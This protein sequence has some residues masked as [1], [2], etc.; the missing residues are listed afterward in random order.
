MISNDNSE[1]KEISNKVDKKDGPI[2]QE[3]IIKMNATLISG[4][5]EH[6]SS[7]SSTNNNDDKILPLIS[8]GKERS[9]SF[10]DSDEKSPSI[11]T[12]KSFLP[13]TTGGKMCSALKVH[14]KCFL[15]K[16]GNDEEENLEQTSADSPSLSDQSKVSDDVDKQIMI[17]N[18][19]QLEYETECEEE[20]IIL[21]SQQELFNVMRS[22]NE[23]KSFQQDTKDNVQQ[24]HEHFMGSNNDSSNNNVREGLNDTCNHFEEEEWETMLIGQT[25][26]CSLKKDEK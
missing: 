9:L 14:Y 10:I 16:N 1:D 23:N 4:G 2:Q 22:R 19:I 11:N 7:D 15:S 17:N 12:G 3:N 5:R 20:E 8:R 25:V 18:I 6:L 13:Q 26:A 21:T 24:Q